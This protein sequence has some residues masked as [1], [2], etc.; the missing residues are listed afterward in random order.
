MKAEKLIAHLRVDNPKRFRL[1]DVDPAD[2]FG[3]DIE[4]DEA[5]DHAGGGDQ[6]PRQL[7]ERLYAQDR[8]ALLVI[9][10]AMDAAGKDGDIEHVMSGVNPQGCQIYS[11][12]APAHEELDHDFLW[13]DVDGAAGARAD[14]DLQPLLL[15]GGAGGA[16][17]SGDPG[18]REA[19]AQAGHQRTSGRSASRTSGVRALLVA[20]RHGDPQVSPA[21]LEGGAAPPAAGAARRAGQALEVLDARRGRA[22]ALGQVH[23]RPTRT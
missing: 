22:Q 16:R 2:S 3:L 17:P 21:H 19:A 15:R 5:R 1:A 18:P 20:E 12:K 9:L 10:Q 8:W 4:K 23:G 6:A 14:R 11:F 13:R 7:Q